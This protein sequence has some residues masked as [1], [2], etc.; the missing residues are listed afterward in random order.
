M[1]WIEF[2]DNLVC[3]EDHSLCTPKKIF[4][5]EN[6]SESNLFFSMPLV[7]GGKLTLTHESKEF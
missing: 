7:G 1:C 6:T 2:N 3:E 4:S 5:I